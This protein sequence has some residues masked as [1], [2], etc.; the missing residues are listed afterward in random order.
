[1]ND[2]AGSAATPTEFEPVCYGM[3]QQAKPGNLVSGDGVRVIRRP[4]RHLVVVADGLGSGPEARR[5]AVTALRAAGQ[6]ADAELAEIIR[7]CH[8]ALTDTRGAALAVL[9]VWPRTRRVQFAGLG[10]VELRTCRRCPLNA[11]S[12][13]GIVGANY[14]P[15]RVFDAEC[16]SSSWL[17]VYTDGLQAKFDLERELAECDLEPQALA[18]H[19]AERYSRANDDLGLVTIHLR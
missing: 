2:T 1:M 18:R 15:P 12:T 8:E 4:E 17:V 3:V 6:R 16:P 5:A 10:N 7:H 14:R 19:L 11:L 9:A 13:S